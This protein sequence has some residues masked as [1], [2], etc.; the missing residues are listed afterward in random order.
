[1]TQE[2]RLNDEKA[3]LKTLRKENSRKVNTLKKEIEKLKTA[4]QSAGGN[5]EKLRQKIT[6]NQTQQKQAELSA[7]QLDEE[8]K[9]M[10]DVPEGVVQQ[11]RTMQSEWSLEKAQYDGARASFKS[12]KNSIDGEVKALEEEQA[13]LQAK[14]NKIAT[15][16]AKAD[17][18][19][20]RITD[21]NARGLDAAERRRQEHAAREVE[22]A[23]IEQVYQER[24]AITNRAVVERMEVA[25]AL[26][27]SIQDYLS[28]FESDVAM[29]RDESVA[30]AVSSSHAA[31]GFPTA[32]ANAGSSWAAA[33]P[34]SHYQQQ[35]SL[36]GPRRRR[37]L[38]RRA[39][40]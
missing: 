7:E 35:Q 2:E 14:R 26:S 24:I 39:R 3:K 9:E 19:L 29:Q 34:Q 21:A 23:R 27:N 12:F 5:D 4:A 25:T 36:C 18:D 6:Q 16:I 15:R 10:A 20:D 11:H 22:W 32:V 37:Q 33:S 40:P 30:A 8:L 17:N 28:S 13:S 31:G 1:M 38:P